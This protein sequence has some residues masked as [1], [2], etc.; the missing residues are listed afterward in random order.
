MVLCAGA[1]TE[2]CHAAAAFSSLQDIGDERTVP[3]NKRDEWVSRRAR[4]AT[5]REDQFNRIVGGSRDLK[6]TPG[7]PES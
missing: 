1:Y 3:S 6:P 7:A 4:R 5:C 2:A